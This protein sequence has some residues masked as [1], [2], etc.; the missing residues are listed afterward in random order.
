MFDF[1]ND[2]EKRNP[3]E[4]ESSS[5]WWEST[6]QWLQ[7]YKESTRK[8]YASCL[9]KF[10]DF[11]DECSITLK[12]LQN[13]RQEL[14]QRG[15]ENE[16]TNS[17]VNDVLGAVRMF[18]EWLVF[19]GEV[20]EFAVDELKSQLEFLSTYDQTVDPSKKPTLEE[21]KIF[22]NEAEGPRQRA[23]VALLAWAGLR[24]DQVLNLS[25]SNVL[26]KPQKVILKV[27]AAKHDKDRPIP[28]EKSILHPLEAYLRKSDRTLG[29]E[30]GDPIFTSRQ[31]N[32][33]SEVQYNR[34][35]R[36]LRSRC[37][38][39]Q[40]VPHSLR[41]FFATYHIKRGI[42]LNVVSEWLGHS[43]PQTTYET[44]FHWC[45][46]K[47]FEHGDLPDIF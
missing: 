40:Y 29:S 32:S 45:P 16:W 42:P 22:W 47:D 30:D 6:E 8:S 24:R 25:P 26:V 37:G 41:H 15:K 7:S 44:Y 19:H 35:F 28:V 21:I 2:A 43:S 14:I 34:K 23:I 12:R 1:E 27:E 46:V 13:F 31:S 4:L 38:L 33:L 3:Y 11:M 36:Q 5:R 17:H 9:S 39:E 10:L 20:N 18:M